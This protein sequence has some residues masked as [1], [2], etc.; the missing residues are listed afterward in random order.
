MKTRTLIYLFVFTLV[1]SNCGKAYSV[2]STLKDQV[3]V[4]LTVYN[5]NLGLVKDIR[6]LALPKG[7]TEL[8]FMDVA[9][10]INPVTVSVKS[11]NK[12]TQFSI[13]EQNYEYDLI[14]QDKILDKYVGKDLKIM[15]W[16][17]YQDRKEV[18]EATLLSN[19]SGQ[20][21]RIE[22]EIY[23]GHPGTKILPKLPENLIEKPTLTWL[24]SNKTGSP[25]ELEVTYLTNNISWK[26]DYVLTLDAKDVSSDLSGWVTI[27]NRSGTTYT[28]AQ[29]KLIAGDVNRVSNAYPGGDMMMAGVAMMRKES[30]FKEKSFFDYHIYDLQRK[31][32]IKDNQTKQINFIENS[33][34]QINK[35]YRVNTQQ[36]YFRSRYSSDAIKQDVNVLVQFKN[37]KENQLGVP[38]PKGVIRLY[39][40]DDEGSLQFV[41]ED[42]IDH[43]PRGEEVELSIGKAFDITVERKQTDYQQK[44]KNSYETEWEI[45][46]R[47]VKKEKV[48]VV[49]LENLY[50]NWQVIR[51]SQD[52]EKVGAHQIQF[53]VS[54]APDQEAKVTYRV[55]TG[56]A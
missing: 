27:D 11:L 36:G 21:Y 31:T 48:D 39:K 12:P 24:F 49:L 34:I 33:G 50:G 1:I 55:R 15:Q 30:A 43:T 5:N 18:V 25:H 40:K 47:N 19:N 14:S 2:K 22:D 38:L 3:S 45:V 28:Q 51:S 32:T 37:S 23:L 8:R 35:E 44:T 53:T 10:G 52:Y 7:E 29:L 4:E 20:V 54:V 56:L 17:E 6:K 42:R 13:L 9:S 41:G 16:N 26:A 46:F